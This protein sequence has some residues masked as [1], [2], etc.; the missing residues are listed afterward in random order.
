MFRELLSNPSCTNF[1]EMKSVIDDSVGRAATNLHLVC[2]VIK[3]LFCC[4]KS[5]CRFIQR[6]PDR[7]LLLTLVQPATCEHV[8]TLTHASLW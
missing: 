6:S 3:S 8:S 7:T 5:A 1:M 2:H 4:Q